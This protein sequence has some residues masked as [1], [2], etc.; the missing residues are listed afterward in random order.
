MPPLWRDGE[1]LQFIAILLRD[2]ASDFYEGLPTTQRESWDQFK[3]AFLARF[4][5]SEAVRWCDTSDLYTMAQTLDESAE[6]FIARVTKKAKYI[7]NIDE[8]LLRSACLPTTTSALDVRR[9]RGA[10]AAA[11]RS[12]A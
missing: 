7:P 9:P 10:T 8:S 11:R 6:D 3:I 1:K 2:T 4:G 12:G 5:R